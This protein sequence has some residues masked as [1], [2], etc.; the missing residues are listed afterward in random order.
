MQRGEKLSVY[1]PLGDELIS[2]LPSTTS[3]RFPN[4]EIIDTKDATAYFDARE[5][6]GFFWASPVQT[7]LELMNGDKRDQETAEQ[8]KASLLDNIGKVRI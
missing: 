2:S 6:A 7:F 8:I 3:S 1:C 5:D 4:L